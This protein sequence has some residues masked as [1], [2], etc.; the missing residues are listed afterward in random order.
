MLI[1]VI[2]ILKTGI[3]YRNVS[4][5]THINWNTIYKFKLKLV[6]YNIFEKLFNKTINEYITEMGNNS[7][8][9]YIFV[10]T[11]TPYGLYRYY[12]CL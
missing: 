5:Y 3:S 4:D 9:Y 11:Y 10:E 12:I 7:K 1:N 8:Q 2:I 6:K